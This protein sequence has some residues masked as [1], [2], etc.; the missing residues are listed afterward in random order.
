MFA[1]FLSSAPTAGEY[2]E[3]HF[4][5]HFRT[6]AWVAFGDAEGTRWVGCFAGGETMDPGLAAVAGRVA[7]VAVG[8]QGYLVE[9]PT[10]ALLHRLSADVRVGA[11]AASADPPRLLAASAEGLFRWRLDLFDAGGPVASPASGVM[12]E[13]LTLDESRG[14]LVYGTAVSLRGSDVDVRFVVDCGAGAM[15][16]LEELE[17]GSSL[18][19]LVQ[20]VRKRPR[21]ARGD[22]G[23]GA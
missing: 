8:G 18:L 22:S 15:E 13:R 14:P 20:W 21:P 3:R 19:G 16:F 11:V 17:E 12:A 5:V 10:G 6:R 23:A 4:G 1:H 9:L 2:P 7:L